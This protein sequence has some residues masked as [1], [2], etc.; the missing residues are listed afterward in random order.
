[1]KKAPRFHGVLLIRKEPG[2]TS[3]DVVHDVRRILGQREVGHAGTLDPMAEGLMVLLLGDGTK[4][5]D[6]LLV[7]DKT[8]EVRVDLRRQ[9]DT[10][11][12][13][14]Q[15]TAEY[16]EKSWTR[17]EIEAAA[18]ALSGPLE[19]QVPQ[20][21]AIKIDGRKLYEY[22]RKGVAV[23]LPVRE[24]NF[25]SVHVLETDPQA[26]WVRVKLHCSKG[27]YVRSWAQALGHRLGGGGCVVELTRVGSEPFAVDQAVTLS[28]LRETRLPDGEIDLEALRTRGSWRGMGQAMP[29]WPAVEATPQESH[30]ILNGVL[31][32]SLRGRLAMKVTHSSGGRVLSS[33]GRDLLALVET[34][35]YSNIRI[36]RVFRP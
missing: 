23:D 15:V 3:H 7:G 17:E 36:R 1:M 22:A 11:D 35:S 32:S 27:S 5:S 24:M 14:G 26:G 29:S 9:T 25:K 30:L 31:T 28:E 4:L 2:P 10:L 16:L 18:A 12:R 34:D 8:Y 20:F 13:E 33:D 21:S 6:L 19:L